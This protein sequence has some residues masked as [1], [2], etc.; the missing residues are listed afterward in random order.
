[1]S[2]VRDSAENWIVDYCRIPLNS[3]CGGIKPGHS[4]LL[5]RAGSEL[6]TLR[7]P[8]VWEHEGLL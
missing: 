8:P 5:S 3:C 1:M 6:W 2:T 7:L 4:V